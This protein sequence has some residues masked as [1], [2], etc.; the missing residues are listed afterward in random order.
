M[1]LIFF[2]L[3]ACPLSVTRARNDLSLRC[4]YAAKFGAGTY[5]NWTTSHL[6]HYGGCLGL[7]GK[8]LGR[9]GQRERL[10]F[11]TID[12]LGSVCKSVEVVEGIASLQDSLW[13]TTVHEESLLC[14]QEGER[15][16]SWSRTSMPLP[17]A[18]DPKLASRHLH[19]RQSHVAHGGIRSVAEFAASAPCRYPR[20]LLLHAGLELLP[21]RSN[22]H[23]VFLE[24]VLHLS[25]VALHV[26]YMI[27]GCSLFLGRCKSRPTVSWQPCLG[28]L[29]VARAHLLAV[30]LRL[31]DDS[32]Q[33]RSS[34]VLRMLVAKAT[35]D[36][37]RDNASEIS[38]DWTCIPFASFRVIHPSSRS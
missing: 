16:D 32:T 38:T 20:R 8:R 29:D 36:Q 14:D 1:C 28:N 22:G 13:Q 30:V 5:R 18:H 3:N 25:V 35:N 12:S 9:N 31:R 6:S 34:E 23:L 10:R 17:S 37:L 11:E 4:V 24:G 21:L 33:H 2:G 27:R 19:I 7:A 26:Q 15:Q